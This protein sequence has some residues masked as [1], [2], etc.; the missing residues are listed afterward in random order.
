M[1]KERKKGEKFFR[2]EFM[3]GGKRISGTFNGKKGLPLAASKQE[4]RD[5]E[6][7]FRIQVRTQLRDG[8]YGKEEGSD[9]FAGFFDGVYMKDAKQ[10]T[11]DWKHTEFRGQVL[12]DFF[13][14]KAFMEIKPL[15]IRGFVNDR[16]KSITKRG[17]TRS[18]VT[19]RKEVALASA[20]FRM[21]IAEGVATEN[22]CASLG[23]AMKRRLPARNKRDRFLSHE[24]EPKLFAQ[25]VGRRA[26]L[27]SIVRFALDTGLR[28]SELCRLEVQ[29][30]NLTQESRFFTIE[31]KRVELEPNGL[32]VA[33]SKS[34]KPRT[35]PLT[36]E[37]RRIAEIQ[38]ADAT[39]RK[40]LFGSF[41]TGGMIREFKT[42]FVGAVRDAGLE[43]FRFHDLR[44]TFASRLNENG[45]D[46][47]AIRDLLGHST[48]AMSSDYT[49]T[50]SETRQRAI[51][52]LNN[53]P[54]RITEK[55]RKLG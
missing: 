7:V 15:T 45:A 54:R 47:F 33:K 52:T 48:V 12:K 10:N 23:L 22:P 40:Y 39:T 25:F 6:S 8:T 27:Y 55:L 44:H 34:G 43:D 24:E 51:G 4:A 19:V 5:R 46:P 31:R 20:V 16:L 53:A 42:A 18:P 37:A 2:F 36:A 49:Q 17:T 26:H 14:G 30:L 41:R 50:S 13:A 32:L 28:K 38:I 11:A 3:E 29:H 9:T 35:V 21:A 1:I